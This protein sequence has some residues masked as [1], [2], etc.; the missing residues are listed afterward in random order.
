[1]ESCKPLITAISPK[2][3]N[4]FNFSLF[5]Q[6]MRMVKPYKR[7]FWLT[8][9][10]TL[11]LSP[12]AVLRPKLI[13]HMVDHYIIPGD[14]GGLTMMA[15]IIFLSLQLLRLKRLSRLQNCICS[16]NIL[17]YRKI[18]NYSVCFCTLLLIS[19]PRITRIKIEIIFIKPFLPHPT[20]RHRYPIAHG[21]F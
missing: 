19:L 3:K 4:R 20:F 13:E 10:L 12:L 5:R 21:E 15:C 14:V 2:H 16:L 8:V 9:G 7:V 18:G 1:M 6:V 11:V 17:H